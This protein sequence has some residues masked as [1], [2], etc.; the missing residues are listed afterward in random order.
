MC[1]LIC[2]TK[3]P[4][5]AA[6]GEDLDPWLNYS[7]KEYWGVC[8]FQTCS[9]FNFIS[10]VSWRLSAAYVD[11]TGIP[12]IKILHVHVAAPNIIAALSLL[13]IFLNKRNL[14]HDIFIWKNDFIY[15]SSIYNHSSTLFFFSCRIEVEETLVSGSFSM[16]FLRHRVTLGYR[17]H[18]NIVMR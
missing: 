12:C 4:C 1:H 14:V 2:Y 3:T 6:A 11:H 8:A 7:R 5:F 15:F 9:S 13:W 18:K 16:M 17:N 10:L